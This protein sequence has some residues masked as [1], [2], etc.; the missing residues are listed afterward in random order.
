[1]DWLFTP[2][3]MKYP[4]MLFMYMDNILICTPNNPALHEEIVHQVLDILEKESLFLKLSKCYFHQCSICYLGILVEGGVIKINPMKQNGLAEWPSKLKNQKHVWSTLGIFGYHWAFI[5]GYA[6][7][8]QCL[9]DLL[10][11]NVSFVWT[12][13]HTAAVEWLKEIVWNGLVLQRPNYEKAFFL[14][15]DALQYVTGAILMQKDE[16]GRHRPVG[17]ISHSLIPTERNYDV[18]DRELLAVIREL[19]AWQHIFLSSPH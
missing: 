16:Q 17:N 11:K 7:I 1:M 13:K 15:V 18:H 10:G 4:G 3:K 12:P 2:L 9:N 19:W 8:I 6:D 14:E 5:P